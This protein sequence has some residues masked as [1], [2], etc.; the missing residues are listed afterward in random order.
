M[1]RVRRGPKAR[2]RRN[3]ILKQV[4]GFHSSRRQKFYQAAETLKRSLHYSYI[5]RRLFKR[6][7]RK[8]WIQRINGACQSLGTSYSRF[9][10][11]LKKK[12]IG[13]NRKMLADIAARDFE[14]FQTIHD[15]VLERNHT[16]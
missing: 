13:L 15:T 10:G 8:L 1:A 4:K 2:Q 12:D 16:F 3:K 7:M 9:M 11:T 14:S 5:S 6:D